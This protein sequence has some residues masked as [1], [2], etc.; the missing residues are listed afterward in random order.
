MG[1]LNIHLIMDRGEKGTIL[2][3]SGQNP[4]LIRGNWENSRTSH[5]NSDNVMGI[6]P[7]TEIKYNHSIGNLN[8]GKLKSLTRFHSM[9][10][11]VMVVTSLRLER[12]T[13]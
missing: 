3:N 7:T 13:Q 6:A 10:H 2:A 11:H 4:T 5:P 9:F 1:I 12:K 8:L